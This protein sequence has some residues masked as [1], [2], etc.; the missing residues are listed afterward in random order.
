LGTDADWAAFTLSQP[1]I[2]PTQEKDD[3]AVPFVA[4]VSQAGP[5][6]VIDGEFRNKVKLLEPADGTAVT[7]GLGYRVVYLS[8]AQL[9]SIPTV[10]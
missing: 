5:Y 4:A 6:F 9:D 2:T 10:G 1:P 8:Q 3:M 7:T